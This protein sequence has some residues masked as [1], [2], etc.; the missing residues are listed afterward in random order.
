MSSLD[1]EPDRLERDR[2]STEGHGDLTREEIAQAKMRTRINALALL[3]VLFLT[4][5]APY[6]WN[7]SALLVIL[8][9]PLYALVRR[10]RSRNS[11]TTGG[12][13]S[14]VPKDPKDPRRYRPI[15]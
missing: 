10:I 8:F 2:A 5:V 6:P 12:P 15:G 9:L 3:L 14:Y 4:T 11:P 13:Y 1:T 7:L